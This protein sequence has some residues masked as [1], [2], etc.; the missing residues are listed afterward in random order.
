M[1]KTVWIINQYASTPDY[2][3]AGRHYYLGQELAK[4]GYKVYLVASANHHLLRVKPELN[5]N[6]NIHKL[7]DGFNMVWCAM[8][9]YKEAHNKKRV[10]GWFFFSWRI[11][12]LIKIIPD[13]PDVLVCSSPSLISFLGAQYISRNFRSKL[14]FEVR[15]IWPLTLID[16]GGYSKNNPFIRVMQWVEDFAYR[17]SDHV[18]SNLKNAAEHMKNHG[19]EPSKFTWIPN[20]FSLREAQKNAPLNIEALSQLPRE[21]FIVGYTGTI[22]V[23]NALDILID[24]ADILKGFDDIRFVLVG[25]GKE[26]KSLEE[27]ALAKKINNVVF[28]KSIPKLEIQSI[29]SEFDAC[30]IGW[31]NDDL[32]KFGIG[33]NK[34]PEYLFSSKPIVHAYSGACDPISENKSGITVP[35][36][37]ASNLASAILKL[38]KMPVSEREEMGARGRKAALEQYEYGMLARNYARILFDQ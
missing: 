12:N 24:A 8:P 10:L 1:S 13:S 37:D 4:L 34:I 15:D 2:G 35:A 28:L 18:I 7:S 16:I 33:A 22:G 9:E 20:G 3:Y 25:E 19:L 27:Y 23:A 26:K 32:Y 38:Y 5:S 30:Y 29:L 11:C 31:L 21:K 14:V 17:K 6:F 36:G